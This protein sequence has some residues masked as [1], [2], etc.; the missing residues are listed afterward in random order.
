ML[1]NAEYVQG[2]IYSS[3]HPTSSRHTFSSISLE[4][5]EERQGDVLE[6][7]RKLNR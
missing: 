6:K 1:R 4:A 3:D 2:R 5:G 7:L